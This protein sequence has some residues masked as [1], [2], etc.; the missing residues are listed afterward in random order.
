M[1]EKH[2]AKILGVGQISIELRQH[3][4]I[5]NLDDVRI[6]RDRQTSESVAKSLNGWLTV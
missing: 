1:F 5:D 3:Y 2:H 4:Q 6:I